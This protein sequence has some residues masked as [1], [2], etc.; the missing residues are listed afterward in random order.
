M[1]S[2]PA[3]GPRNQHLEALY[4]LLDDY[5][6]ELVATKG[7]EGYRQFIVEITR[8]FAIFCVNHSRP[9]TEDVVAEGLRQLGE[10]G[11]AAALE[12]VKKGRRN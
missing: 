4:N 9:G 10:A 6:D 2:N 7:L 1:P 12:E 3:L 5:H 8:L 11:I